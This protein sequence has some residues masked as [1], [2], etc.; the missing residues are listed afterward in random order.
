M[1]FISAWNVELLFIRHLIWLIQCMN[2]GEN[3]WHAGWLFFPMSIYSAGLNA[4]GAI[5]NLMLLHVSLLSVVAAR[6]LIPICILLAPRYMQ[7]Y[8]L[9]AF[10]L[11]GRLHRD[12]KVFSQQFSIIS[13]FVIII[14]KQ[15]QRIAAKAWICK[16][17]VPVWVGARNFIRSACV[18]FYYEC[19]VVLLCFC[20]LDENIYVVYGVFI[21]DV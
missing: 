6:C 3:V 14:C 20:M 17:P 9:L 21:G 10:V 1:P 8:V 18:S 7:Y 11:I 2:V 4:I 13:S 16:P 12:Q 19:N 5:T 15:H